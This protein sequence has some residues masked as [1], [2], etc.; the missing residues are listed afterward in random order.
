MVF[1]WLFL[2]LRCVRIQI[3]LSQKLREGLVMHRSELSTVAARSITNDLLSQPFQLLSGLDIVGNTSSLLADVSKSVAALSMDKTFIRSRQKQVRPRYI[4]ACDGF[5]DVSAVTG[6]GL[7]DQGLQHGRD[8][9]AQTPETGTP[10]VH[11]FALA[12]SL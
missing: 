4:W 7:H 8:S 3:V 10:L 6:D 1:W 9:H 5:R 12:C 2:F 11:H